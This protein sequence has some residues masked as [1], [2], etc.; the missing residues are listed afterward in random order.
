MKAKK[1]SVPKTLYERMIN[2]TR[3][4]LYEQMKKYILESA[5]EH[6]ENP[7][8][9]IEKMEKLPVSEDN[10]KDLFLGAG[11]ALCRSS[12]LQMASACWEN[13]LKYIKK[14]DKEGIYECYM[15]LGRV[16]YALKNYAKAIEYHEKALSV[17][18]AVKDKASESVCYGNSGLSYAGLGDFKKAVEFYLKA[19]KI[20]KEIGQ[21]HYLKIVYE[22]IANA[23]GEM[24]MH[25]EAGKY[26]KMAEAL[27]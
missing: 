11:Y 23:Y 18:L 4:S 24:N 17:A 13:E 14:R 10:K 5:E 22:N 3:Y 20:F 12:H 2:Q 26:K 16:N 1:S 6:K 7:D 21:E 19:E 27:N 15:N 25:K 9:F 8:K